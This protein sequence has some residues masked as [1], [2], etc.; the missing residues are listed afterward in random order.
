MSTSSINPTSSNY[1]ALAQATQ[2]KKHGQDQQA[3]QAVQNQQ[4]SAADTIAQT[5]QKPQASVNTSGQVVGQLIST[6][7]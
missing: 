1:T 2:V 4:Q 5:G 3:L 7:A 6:K